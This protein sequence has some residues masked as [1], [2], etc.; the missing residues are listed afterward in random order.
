M[1]L[2]P[3]MKWW[4]LGE[5]YFALRSIFTRDSGRGKRYPYVYYTIVTLLQKCSAVL[6]EKINNK[7]FLPDKSP[8]TP[9]SA[10]LTS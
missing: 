8:Q 1:L 2:G 9:V 4:E 5:P 3:L 6:K 10:H 7:E